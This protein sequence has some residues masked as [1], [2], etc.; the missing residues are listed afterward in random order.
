MKNVTIIIL[1]IISLSFLFG[2]Q[3]IIE[4]HIVKENQIKSIEKEEYQKDDFQFRKGMV[5]YST[6][7]LLLPQSLIKNYENS[8]IYYVLG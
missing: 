6:I 2:F 8:K 5:F 4:E 7:K 3:Q 1:I